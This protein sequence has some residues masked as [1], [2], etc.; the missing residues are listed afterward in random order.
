MTPFFSHNLSSISPLGSIAGGSIGFLTYQ[1]LSALLHLGKSTTIGNHGIECFQPSEVIQV[2]YLFPSAMDVP[3]LSKFVAEHVTGQ[4]N[5]LLV[6]PSWM[7]AFQ[8]SQ[9]VDSNSSLLSYH[10]NL[11]MDVSVDWVLKSLPFNPLM[12]FSSSVC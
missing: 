2:S 3:F 1:S 10:K 4:F 5:L 6:A 7:E 8:S 9:H 11:V 12:G